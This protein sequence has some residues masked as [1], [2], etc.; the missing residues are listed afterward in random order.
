MRVDQVT[1]D[2]I[3]RPVSEMY[4]RQNRMELETVTVRPEGLRMLREFNKAT[5]TAGTKH[6]A[7]KAAAV[8]PGPTDDGP[9]SSQRAQ[10]AQATAAKKREGDAAMRKREEGAKRQQAPKASKNTQGAAGSAADTSG[11]RT[12][13]RGPV[14]PSVKRLAPIWGRRGAVGGAGRGRQ[15][16]GTTAIRHPG[17]AEQG[18]CAVSFTRHPAQ[19]ERFCRDGDD[20]REAAARP[21]LARD[22]SGGGAEGVICVAG[23]Y[24]AQLGWV[25][26]S[27][28]GPLTLLGP[29]RLDDDE[30]RDLGRLSAS[31]LPGDHL[32]PMDLRSAYHHFRLHPDM[33]K[34]F[35]VRVVMADGVE[36]YFQYLVLPFGWSR[37]GYWFCRL[38]Q[39]FG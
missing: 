30:G 10:R 5:V 26:S 1:L 15:R 6:A 22:T 38:V 34:Y 29:L 18:R 35:T 17:Q 9:A 3:S 39:R 27:G 24:R 37:S 20:Y 21:H 23:V 31:L 14:I 4:T 11:R 16:A 28:R 19:S 2:L 36:R 12:A 8:P 13:G 32:L 25:S 33:R 7:T